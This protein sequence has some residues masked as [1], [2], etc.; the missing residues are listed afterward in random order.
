MARIDTDPETVGSIASRCLL[1]TLLLAAVGL[2]PTLDIATNPF[3]REILFTEYS[4][5]QLG[6]SVALIAG[7]ISASLLL[8]RKIVPQLS[9]L[10]IA[11]LA[12]ALVREADSFLDMLANGLWQ[13][14]VALILI[15][16]GIELATQ[17]KAIRTQIAW[18]S[19]HFSLGLMMAG[20]VIVMGFA[21][22]FGQGPL[23]QQIMGEHYTKTIKYFAEESVELMG[24]VILMI[25]VIE[26]GVASIRR[27]GIAIRPAHH[28]SRSR[29]RQSP[30]FRQGPPIGGRSRE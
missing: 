26:F 28:R 27:F 14:I 18:L 2:L 22:F 21:R 19:S 5:V 16:I 29:E 12:G 1:Y 7:I 25:G 23:W 30:Q 13:T 24:Y 3:G 15:A 10:L 17:K 8:L 11:L 20:F 9:F 4:Y 6:Q